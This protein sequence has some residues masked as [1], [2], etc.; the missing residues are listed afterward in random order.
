MNQNLANFVAYARIATYASGKE[1]EQGEGKRYF[2]KKGD[3]AYQD[4]YF[5][6]AKIFQG[7]E[8]VF[9]QQLPVWS[10]SYR[11]AAEIDGRTDEIYSFLRKSLVE[12]KFTARLHSVCDFSLG[13]WNYRCN[14]SGSFEEFSGEEIIEFEGVMMYLMHYFGGVIT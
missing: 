1:P 9:K 4:L 12:L 10:F 14:G 13:N 8:V 6:Q 2:I 11:G 5:D 3:F 7:Q